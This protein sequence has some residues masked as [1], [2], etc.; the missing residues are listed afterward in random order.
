MLL[1]H[2][3]L[4]NRVLKEDVKE[5]INETMLKEE[6]LK[7]DVKETINETMLKEEVL[8]ED[9]KETINEEV[10]KEDVKE[11]INEKVLKEDVKETINET[12][13][14]EEVLKEDVK[15]TINEMTVLKEDVKETINEITVL[16]EDFVETINEEVLKK[17]SIKLAHIFV[18]FFKIGGG[19]S[20]VSKFSEYNTIFEETIFINNNYNH[21]SLFHYKSNIILYNNYIELNNIIKDYDIIIDHQLYWFELDVTK[22]SFLNIPYNKIIRIIHGVPIHYIDITP[23]NFY[24]SIEL[25]NEINSHS[26]WNNHIKIYNNI[27][28]MINKKEFKFDENNIKVAIV[29]RI[30]EEKIP[31]IFLKLLI[32]FLKYYNKYTFH[33]YGEIDEKYKYYFLSKIKNIKNIFYNGIIDPIDIKNIYLNNDILLH[34]SKMEAGATVVL[35]AMSYGL[36]IIC[37]NTLGLQNAVGNNNYNYLCNTEEEML[38]KLLFINNSNYYKIYENNILKI[39]DE[40]N[41]KIVFLNLI[42]EI[43]FIYDLLSFK[44]EIPN[45]I[46]YIYGLKKQTEEFSFVYYLS[47][48][49][50]YL[51]NKPLVIYFHY[52]YL[53]YGKWWDEAKKYLKLNYI[54]TSNIYWGDKK[55]IK[56]AH[57]ADKIRLEML[58]K[59]GG[60]Y[61]DID[62]IT[63]KS[64][65]DL[66]KYDFVIGIQE[67]NYGDDKITLYC[68][69]ILFSKK[70][71]I[72]LKKWIEKYEDYF[73]PN[74]WC[75]ASIHLPFHIFNMINENDKKNINILEKEYFYHPSYNEVDKIF[76]N[77]GFVHDNLL[78]LHL[79][80]SYS[81]KYYKNITNFNW[82]DNNESLYGLLVKNVYK[83][84]IKK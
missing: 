25:Y 48:L 63:Y 4:N 16:K 64:Y 78:T 15:G 20:Y 49:S 76:E 44:D 52:Q 46:H 71:N 40:N 67:E 80:N 23:Y 68:N 34:P 77:K 3:N 53:P 18:H 26:S 9:V 50:N 17:S 54:N 5:T 22:T 13:L 39:F 31:N 56:Y 10:L 57:K 83:L 79:W 30:N 43:K 24:Y 21:I 35:E 33:F 45:I 11:T 28:V 66:L 69:A 19:E 8:K 12:M 47:I 70:N 81:E 58:L 14:K 62:T 73:K 51:I 38:K 55:I 36:P 74:G 42:H 1:Y 82:C 65:K 72:F 6:V 27:G 32:H 37:R 84:S 59:Y 41:E 60:V 75:E 29:G 61:M 7:E 2:N